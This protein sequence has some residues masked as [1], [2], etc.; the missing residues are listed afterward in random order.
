MVR[1][2]SILALLLLLTGVLAAETKYTTV[3]VDTSR[4]YPTSMA[5]AKAK[6]DMLL[7]M[8]ELAL[9]KALPQNIHLTSLTTDMYVERNKDFDEAT[10]RSIFMMSSSAGLIVR[11]EVLDEDTIFPKKSDVYRY[12]MKYRAT[13]VPQEKVYNSDLDL[14][15]EL[16]ETSLRNNEEFDL[17]VTANQ[18]GFLYIFDFLPDNSVALCFPTLS[19]ENNRVKAKEPWKQRMGVKI[20]EG[21]EHSIETLYF[22]FSTEAIEGWYQFSSNR[23]SEN[24]VFSAGQQSFTLFQNWLFKSDPARRVEKMVQ[25]HIFK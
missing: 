5:P 19:Y 7:W 14:K 20:A 11:E 4:A 8:R 15:V 22:V 17:S 13:V 9:E 6:A 2:L 16:S 10:A 1:T 3:E 21:D 23:D 24:L 12:K 18:D 25:L